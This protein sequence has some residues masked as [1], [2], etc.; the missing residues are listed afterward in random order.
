MAIDY[1]VGSA[2][3]GAAIGFGIPYMH[4]P[5]RAT[6]VGAIAIAPLLIGIAISRARHDAKQNESV[7]ESPP[8][9]RT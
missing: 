1:L 3:L 5:V 9:S 7:D 2:F 4:G 6:L 8:C